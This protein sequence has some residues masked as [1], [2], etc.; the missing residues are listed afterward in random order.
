MKVKGTE[1][2]SLPSSQMFDQRVNS[3]PSGRFDQRVDGAP[4]GQ[5]FDQQVDGALPGQRFDQPLPRRSPEQTTNSRKHEG[6]ENGSV[7]LTL[8]HRTFSRLGTP[9]GHVAK[10]LDAFRLN[11]RTQFVQPGAEVQCVIMGFQREDLRVKCRIREA[12]QSLFFLDWLT[13]TD[14]MG[15]AIPINC[16]TK[17]NLARRWRLVCSIP[18]NL[19]RTDEGGG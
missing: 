5:R 10:I 13:G 8:V 6:E 18:D 3:A 4:S 17:F 15:R 7:S 2:D 11:Q 19:Q 16:E 12:P 14:E 9:Q 1:V